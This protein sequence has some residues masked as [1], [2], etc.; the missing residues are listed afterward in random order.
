M[1]FFISAREVTE[2]DAEIVAANKGKNYNPYKAK[3]KTM[4][5]FGIAAIILGIPLAPIGIG[6]INII[7]GIVLLVKGKKQ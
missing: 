1:G 5:G 6:V 7:V 4:I 3:K 2:K